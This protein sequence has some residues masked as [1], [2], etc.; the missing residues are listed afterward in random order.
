MKLLPSLVLLMILSALSGQGQTPF[1]GVSDDFI[2]DS[3]PPLIT[4]L[5]PNGG[6]AYW[7]SDSLTITW[8]SSDA[9]FGPT[10]IYVGISTTPGGAIT[11]VD[12]GLSVS[13]AIVIPPPCVTAPY[14]K[15]WVM[16]AD[17]FGLQGMDVSDDYIGFIESTTASSGLFA[18]D[19]KPPEVTVT[20][21]NGGGTFG[22]YDPLTVTWEATDDSFGPTAISIGISTTEGGEFSIVATGLPNTGSAAVSPPNIETLYARVWVIAADNFGID[23]VDASDGYFAFDDT[24]SG[25]SASFVTDSKP[26][27]MTV[28]YPN[29]SET[30]NS[31]DS[32]PVSWT[33][34]DESFGSL[35]VTI[36]ISST[37]GGPITVIASG[38]PASGSDIFAPPGVAATRYAKLWIMG[39]D[40]YGLD[41]GDASDSYIRFIE[42]FSSSSQLFTTDSK[43]PEVMLISPNGGEAFYYAEPLKVK[44]NA[45]DDSFGP[46][47]VTI[48]MSTDG[49]STYAIVASGLPDLDSAF[50]TPPEVITDMAKLMIS[51]QDEFGLT[52]SEESETK[53]FLLGFLVDLKAFLE[54]PFNDGGMKSTL[55]NAGYLP[56]VQ[57]YQCSPWNY[58]GTE[59]V[60]A[61]PYGVVDWVLVELRDAVDAASA[62]SATTLTKKAGFITEDGSITTLDGSGDLQFGYRIDQNLFA[63]VWHRDHLGIMSA[64]GLQPAGNLYSYDFTIG[65]GQVY[66][67]SNGFKKL[68]PGMWGLVAGDGDAD[69]TVGNIDKLDVWNQQAGSAGY[70]AGDFNMNGQVDNVDK[71]EYWRPNAGKSSQVP[72]L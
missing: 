22:Y 3:S 50:V 19:S 66:G 45:A 11:V 44:W 35:P 53:F 23:S 28:L 21:P 61:I 43:P 34:W 67:G 9:S 70:K 36:G 16:G 26:P 69:N 55:N 14:A 24:F 7:C 54:G 52:A 8:T 47:P 58:Y 59:T 5:S 12:S 31:C 37:P 18:T 65:E 49:G 33:S 46:T 68:L 41:G 25:F 38:L 32:L 13:G 63:I 30:L 10:P 27:E 17:D 40:D 29:G 15:I 1:S 51:V 57:P 62:T 20:G 39:T 60:A 72:G 6:E 4:V 56:L 48:S 42:N 64:G 71:N 2:T